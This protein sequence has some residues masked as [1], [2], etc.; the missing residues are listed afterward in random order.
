MQAALH[1]VRILIGFS[2]LATQVAQAKVFAIAPA[3]RAE[4]GGTSALLLLHP[5]H[6]QGAIVDIA[7][8]GCNRPHPPS[9][10][11]IISR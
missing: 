9:R 11:L 2:L 8:E 3:K 5:A 4:V 10:Y 7:S 6:G 1:P